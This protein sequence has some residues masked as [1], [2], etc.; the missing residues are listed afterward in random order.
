MKKGMKADEI[1]LDYTNPLDAMAAFLEFMGLD[2]D[3]SS[4]D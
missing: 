2:I 3:L 4:K 1:I